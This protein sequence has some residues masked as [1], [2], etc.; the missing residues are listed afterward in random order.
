VSRLATRAIPEPAPRALTLAITCL[1]LA[2]SALA[3]PPADL[4][5]RA[6]QA[7]AQGRPALAQ[8]PLASLLASAP[9]HPRVEAASLLL[10]EI[11]YDLRLPS[12]PGLYRQ[13]IDRFG[14]AD[15]DGRGRYGLA[16]AL[17]ARGCPDLAERELQ[18]LLDLTPNSGSPFLVLAQRR[19]AWRLFQQQQYAQALAQFQRM[20]ALFNAGHVG[21]AL[22]Y[23][24]AA[25]SLAVDPKGE[26]SL[27]ALARE[28]SSVA[29]LA[30]LAVA[31][32]RLLWDQPDLAAQAISS[33][34][35]AP[36]ANMAI[37]R[38]HTA[39]Q[40]AAQ[41]RL[42][43]AIEILTPL[44]VEA[45]EDPLALAALARLGAAAKDQPPL[46]TPVGL[47][48]AGLGLSAAN[49]WRPAAKLLYQAALAASTP[50]VRNQCLL[51]AAQAWERAGDIVSAAAACAQAVDAAPPAQ[52]MP[53]ALALTAARVFLR[54]GQP[55]PAALVLERM[56]DAHA[57]DALEVGL[58]RAVTQ[59]L[60]GQ[61]QPAVAALAGLRAAAPAKWR[62]FAAL[63]QARFLAE[64]GRTDDALAALVEALSHPQTRPLARLDQARLLLASS[65]TPQIRQAIDAI[66]QD[67]APPALHAE[68]LLLLAQM[69]AAEG[70][71]DQAL[72]GVTS[73]LALAGNHAPQALWKRA[74]LLHQLGRHDESAQTV[75]LFVRQN[76]AASVPDATLAWAARQSHARPS[77]AVLLAE[78][79]AGRA[80]PF[81]AEALA[82]L[83]RGHAQSGDWAAS[84]AAGERLVR[85]FPSSPWRRAASLD[86]AEAWIRLGRGAQA[87]DLLVTGG[88]GSTLQGSWLWAQS[89]AA[90]ARH[91]EAARGL[92]RMLALHKDNMDQDWLFR[93]YR[94]LATACLALDRRAEAMDA[95]HA[96]VRTAPASF[97]LERER[98][99]LAASLR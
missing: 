54:Q 18:A 38:V 14:Y 51:L 99:E 20:S 6:R 25:A 82:V 10:A 33:C 1:A 17:W 91:E 37:L 62:A 5:V 77:D 21:L 27:D 45:P 3:A 57:V 89:F 84:A 16:E 34:D 46:Q 13:C 32:R 67:Q 58:L 50:G 81:T 56:S 55:G 53:P 12:A 31:L 68:A 22:K 42:A 19:L 63:W 26:H 87:R 39:H 49:E 80:S 75:A 4:W 44:V 83:A 29:P 93:A 59:G 71:P 64:D 76:S 9:A 95:C 24:V 74:S 35:G 41:G 98:L 65:Q 2:A 40:L 69:D 85:E 52:Q 8:E 73:A 36:P 94:A 88:L 7:L 15:S 48:A 30:R 66:L 72:S 43:A 61:P 97:D 96:A 90:Q 92:R 78:P 23:D 79:L 86:L 11:A 60:G 70:N 28:P 47:M